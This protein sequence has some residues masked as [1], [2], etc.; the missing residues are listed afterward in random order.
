MTDTLQSKKTRRYFEVIYPVY[1][2]RESS[3]L[4]PILTH[5]INTDNLYFSPT[6][7]RAF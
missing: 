2:D 7:F 3:L 4:L 6:H 5:F 1:H